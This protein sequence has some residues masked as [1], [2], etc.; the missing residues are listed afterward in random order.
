[1]NTNKFPLVVVAEQPVAEMVEVMIP[2]YKLL[3]VAMALRAPSSFPVVAQSVAAEHNHFEYIGHPDQLP[4][5]KKT[6]AEYSSL[7]ELVAV[8]N[9]RAAKE[10]KVS[11]KVHAPVNRE[12]I[13]CICE[14]TGMAVEL[15][16]PKIPGM[17]LAYTNPLSLYKNVAGMIEKGTEYL[18]KLDNQVLA[19]MFLTAYNRYNL[20]A[21][22]PD[23]PSAV[24]VNA[25]LRTAGKKILVDSLDLMMHIHSG[26]QHRLP[27]FSL[28]YTAH[29]EFSSVGPALQEYNKAIRNVIYPGAE[30]AYSKSKEAAELKE[31]ESDKYQD[32]ASYVVKAKPAQ[33]TRLS[34]AEKAYE[35]QFVANRREAK[36]I[37]ARLIEAR[38]VPTMFILKLKPV[39]IGKNLVAMAST[40]RATVAA[41]LRSYKSEDAARLAVI[42]EEGHNPYD[43]FADIDD[44]F[45][46]NENNLKDI[47]KPVAKPKL[48][49]SQ[50]L[51][52][53]RNGTYESLV[54]QVE[55]EPVEAAPVIKIS[56][57]EE[58]DI[59]H[60][61]IEEALDEGA[62]ISDEDAQ[63]NNAYLRAHEDQEANE[64]EEEQE[65]N[66]GTDF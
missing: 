29:K 41:K 20:L 63:W 3:P 58:D 53:K 10:L 22:S 61:E 65:A 64:V 32:N 28:D 6:A 17:T 16:A 60:L 45:D 38:T 11:H 54:S 48:S 43:I 21:K 14:R 62:I 23:N 40:T 42:I 8:S 55:A 5:T 1:M 15:I 25:M 2:R 52:A 27:M 50:I 13:V 35:E 24:A 49:L 37:L 47:S 30:S 56:Y 46:T 39:F 9:T 18:T 57:T 34:S 44:A 7:R 31:I 51:E 36:Q 12:T 33:K 26:N 19:G 4:P 59:R 66:D